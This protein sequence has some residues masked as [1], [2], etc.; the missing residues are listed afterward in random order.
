MSVKGWWG[1]QQ[2][3]LP[4]NG[5]VKNTP[6]TLKW[7]RNWWGKIFITTIVF[8]VSAGFILAALSNQ[9]REIRTTSDGRT[10]YPPSLAALSSS[11]LGVVK[12]PPPPAETIGWIPEPDVNNPT[13]NTDEQPFW[14]SIPP[15]GGNFYPE[16]FLRVSEDIPY[17]GDVYKGEIPNFGEAVSLMYRG[18]IVVWYRASDVKED[19]VIALRNALK[20]T[21]NGLDKVI[22]TPWP[23]ESSINW[24][25]DKSWLYSAWGSW[26]KCSTPSLKVLYQFREENPAAQAPGIDVPLLQTGPQAGMRNKNFPGNVVNLRATD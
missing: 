17:N 15:V 22:V 19:E 11:C 6:Y 4:D 26:Q 21:T 3:L 25:G 16:P 10:V 24:I 7:R 8:V 2:E 14:F 13:V 12:V 1:S 18:W 9:G 5:S 23:Y 20:D